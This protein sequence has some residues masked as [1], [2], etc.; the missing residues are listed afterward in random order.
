MKPVD[1]RYATRRRLFVFSVAVAVAYFLLILLLPPLII[2]KEDVALGATRIDLQNNLRGVLL[3]I[4]GALLLIRG[5]LAAAEQL[6]LARESQLTERFNRA[7]DHLAHE[8]PDIRVGGIFALEQLARLSIEHHRQIIS[9]LTAFLQHSAP[10]HPDKLPSRDAVTPVASDVQ[11]AVTVLGRRDARRDPPDYVM[12]LSRINLSGVDFHGGDYRGARFSGSSFVGAVAYDAR[13]AASDFT[14][15]VMDGVNFQGAELSKCRFSGHIVGYFSDADLGE[16]KFDH[17]ATI[18]RSSFERAHARNASF[19]RATLREVFFDKADLSKATFSS[20][21]VESSYFTE[22]RLE[23]SNLR[24]AILKKV[25]FSG[26]NFAGADLKDADLFAVKLYH[27]KNLT[28][29]QLL[30]AD[31]DWETSE[32]RHA[33]AAELRNENQR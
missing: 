28:S 21:R 18:E 30:F 19:S 27:V 15:V 29:E 17:N 23:D 1:G 31:V 6:Q 16:A 8:R 26:S 33:Y 22:C 7:I 14:N 12:D 13:F 25:D 2:T 4:G 24:G 9:L 11:A 20:A 3:Q 32:S 10:F 5:A